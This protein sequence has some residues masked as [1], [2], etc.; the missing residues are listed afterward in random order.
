MKKSNKKGFTLA[1]LL[2]VIAIIAILIAIAIPTFAGALENAKR[3]TDHANLRN[4]YAM[5]QVANLQGGEFKN[6]N[7]ET[8][9]ALS[10]SLHLVFN[11]DGSLGTDIVPDYAYKIQT[12]HNQGIDD[13]RGCVAC[14]DNYVG[15]YIILDRDLSTG[16]WSLDV[17]GAFS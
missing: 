5:M 17:R 16:I 14:N 1:E 6:V 7:G 11:K 2:I 13:C 8:D 4:A 12:S 15:G 3:Q 10:N 9:N